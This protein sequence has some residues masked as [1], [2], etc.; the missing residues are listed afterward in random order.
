LFNNGTATTFTTGDA[1][2]GGAGT[3]TV[4][5]VNGTPGTA[6][7]ITPV[8][9]TNVE[10][11]DVTGDVAMTL[12][13]VTGV[14]SLAISNTTAA[15][16][17]SFT[18]IAGPSVALSA[19]NVPFNSTVNFQILDTALTG[20]ADAASLT[21]AGVAG[22]VTVQSSGSQDIESAT[23][24]ATGASSSPSTLTIGD[25][26]G[27]TITSL[28]VKGDG[29]ITF[30]LMTGV[31]SFNATDNS[32]GVSF[33]TQIGAGSSATIIG[34]SGGD[35]LTGGAGADSI[36]GNAGNDTI[37]IG[38]SAGGNDMVDAGAGNDTVTVSGADANDTISGGDGTDVM[39]LNAA[40]LAY[41]ATSGTNAA[42]NITGFETIRVT[43][44]VGSSSS[45]QDL[46]GINLGNTIATLTVDAGA[47]TVMTKAPASLVT[48]T[49]S[50][51]AST[52]SS[53]NVTLATDTTADALS[54][55]LG[56]QSTETSTIG[57]SVTALGHESITVN[58]T[59]VASGGT[60]DVT[61]V[62]DK[63]ATLTL[64]GS[65]NLTVTVATDTTAAPLKAIDATGFT[66]TT[67]T[68][69]TDSTATT[70]ATFTPGSASSKYNITTGA[71]ADV[72]TGGALIDTITSGAGN[73]TIVAGEG[74]DLITAGDGADSVNAGLGADSVVGG[75]GDDW[76]NAEGAGGN[77][78]LNGGNGNDTLVGGDGNDSL[79]GGAGSDSIVG[80]AGADSITAD[81]GSDTINGGAGNDR[82]DMA[83]FLS[84]GDSIV[85]GDGEDTIVV[86]GLTGTIKPTGISTVEIL[87]GT[88]TAATTLDLTNVTDLGALRLSTTAAFDGLKF[89]SA[90]KAINLAGVGAGA[91][92]ATFDSSPSAL[93]ITT[94]ARTGSQ[95]LTIKSAESVTITESTTA[96]YTGT[97]LASQSLSY[98]TQSSLGTVT[99]DDARTVAFTTGNLST[100]TTVSGK[101]LTIGDTDQTNTDTDVSLA[102]AE[103]LTVTS[104][105]YADIAI[106]GISAGSATL[107]TIAITAGTGGSVQVGNNAAGTGFDAAYAGIAGASSGQAL[108][109]VT[110]TTAGAGSTVQLGTLGLGTSSS[111]A[112]YTLSAG[113][114]STVSTGATTV[115]SIANLVLTADSAVTDSIGAF[116]TSGGIGKGTITTAV[117]STMDYILTDGSA[118]TGAFGSATTPIVVAGAGRTNIVITG[119]SAYVSGA[120][121]S[122][123]IDLYFTLAGAGSAGATV[124]GGS[125]DDTLEGGGGSDH[126]T[127]GAGADSLN[128]GG[129]ADT[130]SGGTGDD[131]LNGGS[132]IDTVSYASASA[133]ITVTL[134]TVGTP[135]NGQA[136]SSSA[137][138]LAGF[139][140]DSLIAGSIEVLIGS[141]Y[142]DTLTAITDTA[143]T[144]SGGAGND[145]I[146]GGTGADSLSGG[147]G[148]DSINAGEGIDVI[149][150]G[151]GNDTIV[152]GETTSVA[153]T[154]QF[155]A[156][157]NGADV[158][159]GFVS[160]T[161][162]I[163]LLGVSAT[164]GSILDSDGISNGIQAYAA[165]TTGAVALAGKA[166]VLTAAAITSLDTPA[167][168]AALIGTGRVFDIAASS[169]GYILATALS[170]AVVYVYEVANDATAAVTSSEVTLIGTITMTGNYTDGTTFTSSTLIPG[171]A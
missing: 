53:A 108:T 135:A 160:G 113:V 81:A 88:S 158:I 145:T 132:G 114:A 64:A 87:R 18:S 8:R 151:A 95:S 6:T 111:I 49:L 12:S 162:K 43:G 60:N 92:T 31:K 56:T 9:W 36:M 40:T 125:A 44:A 62:A 159:T 169:T 34:G 30:P 165:T 157:A 2:D 138:A 137:S 99:L 38:T 130:L 144:I 54:V 121:A 152:L 120:S 51:G 139:G 10:N 28:T 104:G 3:D 117:G 23:V 61:L 50:G 119:Q 110:I 128:G 39:R 68:V 85:G 105:S 46:T 77:D 153:D 63:M 78:T 82:I 171:G 35:T 134:G 24:T 32:G 74:N 29:K 100:S 16:I 101:E 118:G 37:D 94:A 73:D 25:S 22:A 143:S 14:K 96:D 15:V 106:K 146:T 26:S 167:E 27:T 109:S 98:T 45:P 72:I 115:A 86:S 166:A 133:A 147:D 76:I 131:V 11:I 41:S 103:S 97:S 90:L 13:S 19:T 116:T 91:V 164:S 136:A 21:L 161:D 58:S 107:Q 140:T 83:G 57:A 79:V 156:T 47:T 168:V 112:T 124:I 55:N 154:L 170:Q 7:A 142:G 102:A 71:G 48:V 70:G 129:G 65:K 66:G 141:A 155:S 127:G 67:L 123:I 4:S 75:D 148:A 17:S 84:S 1:L 149:L 69:T 5:L 126:L 33:A 20:S 80:N 89:P 42:K 59:A 93:T 150:G 163:S 122:G 52:G